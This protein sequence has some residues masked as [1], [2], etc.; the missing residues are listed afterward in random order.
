MPIDEL[1]YDD[2]AIYDEPILC[3]RC[4]QRSATAETKI[5][6]VCRAELADSHPTGN[7]QAAWVQE[8]RQALL[9]R[10]QADPGYGAQVVSELNEMIDQY[11][12]D[13]FILTHLKTARQNFMARVAAIQEELRGTD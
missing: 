6:H 7:W 12:A 2:I 9:A 8:E 11:A 4:E 3:L 1:Y 5:C 10:L 13:N